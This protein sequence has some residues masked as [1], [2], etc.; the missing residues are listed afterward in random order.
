M[1]RH[2]HYQMHLFFGTEVWNSPLRGEKLLV[3][4]NRGYRDWQPAKR[5]PRVWIKWPPKGQRAALWGSGT[6]ANHASAR[7]GSYHQLE[8]REARGAGGRCPVQG[9]REA[10]AAEVRHVRPKLAEQAKRW[11]SPWPPLMIQ[12][13]SMFGPAWLR[14]SAVLPAAPGTFQGWS[15]VFQRTV[16]HEAHPAPPPQHQAL[17]MRGPG[18]QPA[19][20]LNCLASLKAPPASCFRLPSNLKKEFTLSNQLLT[21]GSLAGGSSLSQGKGDR[22][23]AQSH[24]QKVGVSLL[25]TGTRIS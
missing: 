13:T 2:V 10:W 16:G 23:H 18:R 3:N 8:S 7:R 14:I 4:P 25:K 19:P 17:L 24:T 6:V 21:K 11:P 20:P 15:S 5:D 9:G 22:P 12:E 1:T